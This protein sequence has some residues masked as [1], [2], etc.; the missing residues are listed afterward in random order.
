MFDIRVVQFEHSGNIVSVALPSPSEIAVYH[1]ADFLFHGYRLYAVACVPF[2]C[3]RTLL[4]FVAVD[5]PAMAF[6]NV[7][8][9]ERIN[10]EWTAS[11]Y[12]AGDPLETVFLFLYV[13][14]SHGFHERDCVARECKSPFIKIQALAS[15]AYPFEQVCRGT[16]SDRSG[17]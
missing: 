6:E 14:Q 5:I 9:R 15:G 17:I 1:I 13:V 8:I 11:V 3:N 2:D 4:D 7:C 16:S 12:H 10:D